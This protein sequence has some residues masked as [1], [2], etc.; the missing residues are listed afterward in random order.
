MINSAFTYET[1]LARIEELRGEA[2]ERRRAGDLRRELARVHSISGSRQRG[3]L[4]RALL[5]TLSPRRPARA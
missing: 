5:P 2:V 1:G 4:R 3:R